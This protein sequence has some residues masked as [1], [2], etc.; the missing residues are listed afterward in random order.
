MAGINQVLSTKSNS[1]WTVSNTVDFYCH[2]SQKKQLA[3][4]V[5]IQYVENAKLIFFSPIKNLKK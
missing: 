3:D 4:L 1:R 5:I 2:R